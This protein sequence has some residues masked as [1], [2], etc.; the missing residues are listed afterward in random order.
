VTKVNKVGICPQGRKESKKMIYI[1]TNG[2]DFFE[3][4]PPSEAQKINEAY[5]EY[6]TWAEGV[7]LEKGATR[8]LVADAAEKQI[9]Q[10]WA[11]IA[12]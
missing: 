3:I 1:E 10:R 9:R 6:G 5:V 2:Y 8:D 4:V 7:E 11:E 12:K